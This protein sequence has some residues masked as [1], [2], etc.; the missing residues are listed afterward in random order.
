[1]LLLAVGLVSISGAHCPHMFRRYPPLPRVLPPEPTL[2]QVIEAVNR[3][4]S[5]IHSFSTT[6][7]TL[8]GPGI[9][10][11]RAS[12]AFQRPQRLR[13]RAEFMASPELDLGSNDELFWFWI[14]RSEP[15]A[16]YFC[17]HDR[18]PFSRARQ[19]IPVDPDW[20]ME[21]LGTAGFDP[22]L[23][24]QG[25][26][27]L[28]GGRLEVRTIRETPQGPTTKA[29]VVDAVRGCILEQH[30][31]DAGGQLLAS[32]VASNHHR[33]PYS[34]LVMP[35]VVKIA[36]P[37]AKFSMQID[38]GNVQVNRLS[39]NPAELW[40]MP[41]YPGT[42]VVDLCDPNMQPPLV[43][44]PGMPPGMQP[45][46]VTVRPLPPQHGWGQRQY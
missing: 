15:P 38:L 26:F 22:M 32:S 44:P 6:R 46:A 3:N 33:D 36:S 8:S 25:P 2:D 29:T 11:L 10:T 7:A 18:F 45:A 9:P 4:N 41:Q 14:K 34:G 27:V 19:M 42:P 37:T 21:A 16:V 31:Y 1:M 39:G 5:Q 12:L 24:H 23:P 20:L 30:V 28:P 43:A 17:R 35:G 13:L 40:A